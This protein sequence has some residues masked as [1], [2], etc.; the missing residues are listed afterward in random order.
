MKG[1]VEDN[2]LCQ[3]GFRKS[4]EDK[5]IDTGSGGD[6]PLPK[7]ICLTH[8]RGIIIKD[9]T[10]RIYKHSLGQIGAQFPSV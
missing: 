8:C 7:K 2:D 9:D 1:N 6:D 10:V 3:K 5:K 4:V